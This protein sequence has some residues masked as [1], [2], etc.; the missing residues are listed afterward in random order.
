MTKSPITQNKPSLKM[1]KTYLEC[2]WDM[3]TT[4]PIA[5]RVLRKFSRDRL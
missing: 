5:L 4:V 3:F 1:E 2:L